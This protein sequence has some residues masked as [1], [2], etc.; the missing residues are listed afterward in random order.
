MVIDV[1]G[2]QRVAHGDQRAGAV[3]DAQRAGA[4]NA[5]LAHAAR[6]DGGVAGHAAARGEDAFRRMHAVDVL[7]AGLDAHQDHLL[8]DFSRVL[9]ILGG[10]HDLAGGRPRRGGQAGADDLALGARVDGRVQQLVERG[11]VDAGDGL[12]RC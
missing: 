3:V 5:G 4:G 8:A 7:G 1:A 6:H 11:R 12:A 10:E 2:L 9:G